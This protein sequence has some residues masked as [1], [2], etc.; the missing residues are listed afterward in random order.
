MY[1]PVTE[2]IPPDESPPDSPDSFRLA[3]GDVGAVSERDDLPEADH[4]PVADD[5]DV[6]YSSSRSGQLPP[7]RDHHH[8]QARSGAAFH[9]QQRSRFYLKWEPRYLT[10]LPGIMKMLQL[11]IT[12]TALI[13]A[14]SISYQGNDYLSLPASWKFR[15]FVF[16]SVLSLLSCVGLLF[17][18]ATNVARLLPLDWLMMVSLDTP[19]PFHHPP[20]KTLNS[21]STDLVHKYPHQNLQRES[22]GRPLGG[23]YKR[24]AYRG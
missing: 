11:V 6:E 1:Q 20:I 17:C 4:S 19:S 5:T 22:W 12:L 15:V 24:I 14:T 18:R 21:L 10:T 8:H 9:Q 7:Y 16:T 3:G 2:E 13:C 23:T